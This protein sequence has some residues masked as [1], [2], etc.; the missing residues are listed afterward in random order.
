MEKR[1]SR[2]RIFLLLFAASWLAA[3][4]AV[5]QVFN[6]NFPDPPFVVGQTYSVVYS[7]DGSFP[8]GTR[9]GVLLELPSG[10]LFG[11]VGEVIADGAVIDF[12]LQF[13]IPIE[14]RAAESIRLAA[15]RGNFNRSGRRDFTLHDMVVLEG[16]T[17]VFNAG[18]ATNNG[19]NLYGA[20]DRELITHP[21]NLSDLIDPELRFNL[22][23]LDGFDQGAPQFIP[24]L[25]YSIDG[26]ASFQPLNYTS[27][28]NSSGLPDHFL[29]QNGFP[30]TVSIPTELRDQTE[31]HLRWSQPENLG[32]NTQ[33]WQLYEARRQS[34]QRQ[35]IDLNISSLAHPALVMGEAE[36]LAST[37]EK[38]SFCRIPIGY[39]SPAM[40]VTLTNA[41][42]DILNLGGLAIDG[43]HP[44]DF[45]LES[46]SCSGQLITPETACTFEVRFAPS[47]QGT[48]NAKISISS[49]SGNE[50]LAITLQGVGVPPPLTIVPSALD[51][52]QISAGSSASDMLLILNTSAITRTFGELSLGGEH[53][54][55]FE[56]E[57][58]DCSQQALAPGQLC[59]V[60][61]KLT[62]VND[63]PKSARIEILS[64][65]YT[66]PDRV[67]LLGAGV[68][69]QLS[70]TPQSLDFGTL[71]NDQTASLPFLVRNEGS[72]DVVISALQGPNPPFEIEAIDCAPL[73]A[74]LAPDATC[75]VGISVQSS[76]LDGSFSDVVQ[77]IHDAGS[78]PNTV[79][80]KV[81]F[82]PP[83]LSADLA[84][85]VQSPA[86]S[87]PGGSASFGVT[88]VNQGP[89]PATQALVQFSLPAHTSLISLSAANAVCGQL[90]EALACSRLSALPADSEWQIVLDL[91]VDLDAPTGLVTGQVTV[92]AAEGDPDLD[93]NQAP[94]LLQI[95]APELFQDRFEN[96]VG[97]FNG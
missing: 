26:C 68:T 15:Y 49:G 73:P 12:P 38:L 21:T 48:R 2:L 84:V 33:R 79:N 56:I 34:G 53:A 59:R 78:G 6:I 93:D 62:P 54:D 46:D 29:Y 41:G 4:A 91:N 86:G 3:S 20:T 88:V 50:L 36:A 1:I 87:P 35:D 72:A 10:E 30:Y 13:S 57:F 83:P 14:A 96:S 64:N 37:A 94:L 27:P 31:V 55:E 70:I 90:G 75:T 82:E 81:R 60:G 22:W 39:S 66:S 77:V 42:T 17:I 63:G 97:D 89:E 32:Q 47:L 11:P 9:I 7:Y 28:P 16:V 25:E 76:G 52:G 19:F 51:F 85:A 43:D 80:L 5:A 8:V 92:S 61:L 24:R 74:V 65:A 69:S 45:Q 95:N 67:D 40:T 58:N 44:S 71:G 18:P 23:L